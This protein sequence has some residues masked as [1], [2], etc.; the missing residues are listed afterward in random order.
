MSDEFVLGD[1]ENGVARLAFGERLNADNDYFRG[2]NCMENAR[3]QRSR[4][5]TDTN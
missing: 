2:A 5:I 4:T 1:S 3:A